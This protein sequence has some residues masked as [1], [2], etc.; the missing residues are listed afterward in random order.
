MLLLLLLR[1]SCPRI[2][3]DRQLGVATRSTHA[4]RHAGRHAGRLANFK[5]SCYSNGFRYGNA[6]EGTFHVSRLWVLST[7][8]NYTSGNHD[9]KVL[10]KKES[11][12]NKQK[13]PNKPQAT[14]NRT[15]RRKEFSE[16]LLVLFSFVT[17]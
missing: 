7:T 8:D 16:K 6:K 4:R 10:F 15:V 12:T 14:H 1:L 13:Y 5:K 9:L 17:A 3:V 11:G 2:G